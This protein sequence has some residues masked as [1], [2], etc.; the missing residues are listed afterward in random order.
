MIL[1]GIVSAEKDN[2]KTIIQSKQRLLMTRGIVNEKQVQGCTHGS[3]NSRG[4]C[5][6]KGL[7]V[8]LW[9]SYDFIFYNKLIKS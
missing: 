3:K 1:V 4:Y 5:L 6:E 2:F 9:L 8:F 7:V